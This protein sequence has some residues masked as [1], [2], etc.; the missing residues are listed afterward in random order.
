MLFDA[1]VKGKLP[2]KPVPLVKTPRRRLLGVGSRDRAALVALFRCSGGSNWR[3]KKN[4]DTTEKV[5]A[6]YGVDVDE[7][8][9]VVGLQLPNNNLQ[10]SIPKELAE[11]SELRILRLSDNMLTGS[12][13]SQLGFLRKLRRLHLGNNLLT[14]SIP[15]DL[16]ELS[17]L[18]VLDL[19]YNALTGSIS[20]EF[21]FMSTLVE[22]RLG[23]NNLSGPIPSQLGRLRTLTLLDL[24]LNQLSGSIPSELGQL[25]S[26]EK[27][28][29]ASNN[30]SGSI[31]KALEGMGA[32]KYL[33]LRDNQLT[34]P[35]PSKPASLPLT[36]DVSARLDVYEQD[37]YPPRQ[38]SEDTDG[39]SIAIERRTQRLRVLSFGLFL[40]GPRSAYWGTENKSASVSRS[41][42]RVVNL[43]PEMVVVVVLPLQGALMENSEIDASQVADTLLMPTGTSTT[44]SRSGKRNGKAAEIRMVVSTRRGSRLLVWAQRVVKPGVD[45]TLYPGLVGP[46]ATPLLGEFRIQPSSSFLDA[47]LDAVSRQ[48]RVDQRVEAVRFERFERKVDRLMEQNNLIRNSLNRSSQGDNDTNRKGDETDHSPTFGRTA[49]AIDADDNPWHEEEEEESS[50]WSIATPGSAEYVSNEK[51]RED[52]A[53][54]EDKRLET[55]RVSSICSI[56]TPGSAESVSNEKIQEVTAAFEDIGLETE[57]NKFEGYTVL[58][59]ILEEG[60]IYTSHEHGI[61]LTAPE[62]PPG[63]GQLCG[64]GPILLE[65]TADL[66]ECGER[67]FLVTSVLHCFPAGARFS[68]PLLLDLVLWEAGHEKES[69]RKSYE[70]LVRESKFEPWRVVEEVEEHDSQ[71]MFVRTRIGHFTQFTLGIAPEG[72]RFHKMNR[73]RIEF[74]PAFRWLSRSSVEAICHVSRNEYG[75][76]NESGRRVYI[77]VL[78]HAWK[79]SMVKTFHASVAAS[80]GVLNAPVDV[81]FENAVETVKSIGFASIL[82]YQL[83]DKGHDSQRKLQ[84]TDKVAVVLIATYEDDE[85]RLWETRSADPGD[86]LVLL[87]KCFEGLDAPSTRKCEIGN[88][89]STI[90]ALHALNNPHQKKATTP[91][92]VVTATSSEA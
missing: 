39:K 56:A 48:S 36:R 80:V 37:E 11:L 32:L 74:R 89:Q 2:Q 15:T 38:L 33:N 10:G 42:I 87:P 18:E 46:G 61:R 78:P 20:A 53:A 92:N 9:R 55:E 85:A 21:G 68:A 6:W 3:Q 31:P 71:P 12:I 54:F 25:G 90:L 24:K 59:D 88:V 35:L 70:V 84:G 19:S 73:R 50:I 26:L 66:V 72:A 34:G 40:R 28:E 30:L 77:F 1:L 17:E 52:T 29:L 64:V 57:R 82:S 81:D 62:Q 49:L 47:M 22:L 83:G 75:F 16:A 43:T 91:R 51:L 13:P 27:L 76:W 23:R 67:S 63:R 5:S 41:E 60:K 45:V 79:E 7:G 86:C 58:T 65:R 69:L 8:G 4:W 44:V 14:D